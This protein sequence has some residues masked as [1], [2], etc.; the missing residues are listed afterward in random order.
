MDEG[1]EE[2]GKVKKWMKRGRLGSEGGGINDN[3]RVISV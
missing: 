3:K 2:G 1:A